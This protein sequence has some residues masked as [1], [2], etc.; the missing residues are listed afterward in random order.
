VRHGNGALSS[1]GAELEDLHAATGAPLTARR[2]WLQAWID[3][4]QQ[5]HPVV[6]GVDGP[7]GR[8]DALAVLGARRERWFGRIVAGG[9]GPSDAVMLPARDL[10][11][12]RRLAE[13]IGRELDHQPSPWVLGLRHVVASDLVAERLH[14]GLGHTRIAAG[15]VSPMLRADNG[16][17]LRSYVTSSHH[18]G[19]SR[20]R[21][22]MVRERLEPQT[23]HLYDADSIIRVLPEVERVYRSRDRALGRRCLLDVAPHRDF[24]RLVVQRHAE[25]GQVC[26]STLELEGRLAAYTLCFLDGDTFRMWNHRFDPDRGRW[27]PGKLS[28]DDSVAHALERGCRAYDFMRGSEAYKNSYANR[29]PV[30]RDLY[31]S[32]GPATQLAT[33]L[34]LGAQHGL[35]RMDESGGAAAQ[36]ARAARKARSTWLQR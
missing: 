12:A 32:S 7:D 18:R 15:D 22:R 31:A 17:S 29:W 26:L 4:F 5:F 21:N 8:L 23:Q 16:G 33:T 14:G 24:F 2:T 9:H 11:A 30:A 1:L 6:V 20:V 34:F 19:I 3:S 27:S 25:Q 28:V 35:R 36:L 13:A 10:Q